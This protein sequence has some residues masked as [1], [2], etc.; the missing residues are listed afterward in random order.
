MLGVSRNGIST[1]LASYNYTSSL[2]S[3]PRWIKYANQEMNLT[4]VDRGDSVVGIMQIWETLNSPT[5]TIWTLSEFTQLEK[6]MEIM[7]F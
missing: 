6:I 4:R 7:T 2:L 1:T 3:H 5:W